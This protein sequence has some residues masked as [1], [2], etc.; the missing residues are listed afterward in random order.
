MATPIGPWIETTIVLLA[1]IAF[2]FLQKNHAQFT[3]S[4]ALTTAA[5]G[6][7]GILAT[8]F[9]FSLPALYFTDPVTFTSWLAHPG[10]FCM[11]F[12]AIAFCGASF[13]YV[14]AD[15]CDEHLIEQ[16]RLPFPIGELIYKTIFSDNHV[17]QAY[18]LLIGFVGVQCLF[19]I[20]W[21]Y[22]IMRSSLLLF[23]KIH[24]SF[25]T[26]P[27]IIVPLEQLPLYLSIGFV[28]GHVIAKPLLWG[29]LVKLFC[30]DPLYYLY[31]HPD[32]MLS[33][34]IF[35]FG[36]AQSAGTF[37]E[38]T[39]AFCSGIVVYGALLPFLDLPTYVQKFFKK[40][41]KQDALTWWQAATTFLSKEHGIV[42]SIALILNILMLVH[43][44]FSIPAVVFICIFS[45]ICVYQMLL[46][47]GQIGI[48]PLGRF[49][50]FVMVPGMLLFGFNAFQ[51]IYV[52]TFV[53]VAGGVAADVLFG[54][55][56]GQL[57]S[58]SKK[59]MQLFQILGLVAS[60]VTIG[61]VFWI[62][63]H[64]LGFGE[65]GL[66]VVKAASRALLINVKSFNMYVLALGV[67]AGFLLK[68]TKV[69]SALL[70]G[71]I[72]MPPSVSL[73][74][75]VGGLT[76]FVIKNRELYYPLLSGISAGSV[77]WILL[78]AIGS[79]HDTLTTCT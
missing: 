3:Q 48:V 64:S 13:G 51:S 17:R 41:P 60:C 42:L 79:M 74:L 72:L 21:F 71:G 66:P 31:S 24:R 34:I 44:K 37:N 7:G 45:A 53:E 76:S 23:H 38:F 28:T 36:V 8:G 25:L 49:A 11:F 73:M 57:A 20:N 75:I 69:N 46:I 15:I 54:R 63:A 22:S 6:I 12:S 62:F 55:R 58:I 26:I 65:C 30:L 78:K 56:L 16:Q 27:E 68:F 4:V 40:S 19:F 47:A 9:G 59:R 29:F 32:V 2:Y 67:L 10:Y 5:A 70:L 77:I 33:K 18:E 35:P 50:T 1:S 43:L 39:L 52:A 61:V 14:L